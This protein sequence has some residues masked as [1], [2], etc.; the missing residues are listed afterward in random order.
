MISIV[1]LFNESLLRV[2]NSFS[3]ICQELN[4]LN[5]IDKSY[6]IEDFNF[7]RNYYR[8][9]LYRLVNVVKSV[10]PVPQDVQVPSPNVFVKRYK[11]FSIRILLW[12]AFINFLISANE[13][14]NTENYLNGL[15]TPTNS[16]N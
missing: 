2:Q 14:T 5:L 12:I 11:K 13:L 7:I 9:E 6:L 3:G 10:T 1:L 4:K 15:V 16:S 8:K